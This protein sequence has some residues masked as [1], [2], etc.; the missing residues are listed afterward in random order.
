MAFVGKKITNSKNG[1]SYRFIQTAASTG[2]KM[3]EMESV[4]VPNSPEPILHYHP[5]QE[6]YFRILDGEVTVRIGSSLKVLRAGDELH[7]AAGTHHAMW[8]PKDRPSIVNWKTLPAME[9]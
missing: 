9:T 5:K 7:I 8:N 4:Y 2:G 3:L 1:Q 6:E